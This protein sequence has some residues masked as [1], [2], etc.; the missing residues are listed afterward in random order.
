GRVRSA[1]R[2]GRGTRPLRP[3]L[4]RR[5]DIRHVPLPSRTRDDAA[6]ARS[7]SVHGGT[8]RPLVSFPRETHSRLPAPGCATRRTLAGAGRLVELMVHCI[9]TA[10]LKLRE[11]SPVTRSRPGA[12]LLSGASKGRGNRGI[13]RTAEGRND[14]GPRS[15]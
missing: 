5:A 4:A 7:A 3:R 10:T 15:A 14:L 13:P 11:R 8:R 1:H 9:P 6:V 2:A 12:L